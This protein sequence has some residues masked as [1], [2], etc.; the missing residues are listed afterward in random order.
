LS[1]EAVAPVQLLVIEVLREHPVSTGKFTAIARS[2]RRVYKN[3]LDRAAAAGDTLIDV[4]EL[5]P[6]PWWQWIIPLA[7]SG[8]I[9]TVV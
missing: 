3:I 7:M 2:S 9:F 8:M 5:G 6:P 1:I 4:T